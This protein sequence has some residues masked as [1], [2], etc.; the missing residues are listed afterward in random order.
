LFMNTPTFNSSLIQTPI[1]STSTLIDDLNSLNANNPGFA[2]S[3]MSNV[4]P[5][6]GVVNSPFKLNNE[7][8]LLSMNEQ[9]Q[10]Q[11]QSP[12]N[13]AALGGFPIHLL[14]MVTRLNKIL[15][16]KKELVTKLN[17]MNSEAERTKVNK[18]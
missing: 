12:I 9:Q 10:Q 5:M 15:T 11:Q 17:Q 16:V 7:L 8:I 13:A 14:L 18:P 4:D 6:L 2:A 1:L 3:F